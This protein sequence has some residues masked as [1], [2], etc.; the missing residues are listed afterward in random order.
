M[1]F[2]KY[3]GKDK[4]HF[5]YYR[6]SIFHPFIVVAV[7]ETTTKEGQIL[8]S[9]YLMTTSLQRAAEKPWSYERLKH[10][11]NPKDTKIS[12]VNKFR[13]SDIPSNRFTKPYTGWHLSKEDELLIDGLEK[14][15][16]KRENKK[17]G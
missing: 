9:G 10:N 6:T 13:I 17:R 5:R 15:F 2:R 11:P 16:K 7:T 4:Y 1:R 14:R 3:N 8:I 12:F